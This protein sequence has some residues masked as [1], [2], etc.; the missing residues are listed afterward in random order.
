[1][2]PPKTNKQTMAVV[3]VVVVVVGHI[4]FSRLGIN[5][6]WL[7]ILMSVPRRFVYVMKRHVEMGA[8]DRYDY[9][10]QRL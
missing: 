6:V 3:V 8:G 10:Y 1:M 4:F 7:P 2:P 9:H 5:R